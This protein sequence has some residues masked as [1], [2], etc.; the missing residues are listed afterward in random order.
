MDMDSGKC[1][2]ATGT[3]GFKKVFGDLNGSKKPGEKQ[4]PRSSGTDG[5]KKSAEKAGY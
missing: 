4:P 3:A 2:K 1:K 5:K